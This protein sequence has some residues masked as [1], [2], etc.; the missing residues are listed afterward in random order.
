MANYVKDL[1]NAGIYGYTENKVKVTSCGTT[2]G[3]LHHVPI[4]MKEGISGNNDTFSITDG[5]YPRAAR[6]YEFPLAGSVTKLNI[7]V[8]GAAGGDFTFDFIGMKGG[9]LK[10]P[11][12]STTSVPYTFTKTLS[13]G[14]WDKLALV[15]SGMIKG[16]GYTIQAGP[17][18]CKLT[19]KWSELYWE[20]WN[21]TQNGTSITGTMTR[22]TG[23]C[24]GTYKITGTYNPPN[25]ALDLK[26]PT[27]DCCSEKWSGT[28]SDDCQQLNGYV[29]MYPP[30]CTYAGYKTM[31]RQ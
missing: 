28:V 31:T 7:T 3:P 24:T 11:I 13:A 20:S 9:A 1:S 14:Q 15:V 18:A 12:T 29:S 5:V 25:V 30:P 27:S 8:T 26:S 17:S 21:L 2:Y 10:T 4:S 22:L 19:G 6:Y 23:S 16:G